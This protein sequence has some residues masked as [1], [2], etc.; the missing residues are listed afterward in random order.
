MTEAEN[1][2]LAFVA[3]LPREGVNLDAESVDW[4][5]R[6]MEAADTCYELMKD[7]LFPGRPASETVGV[8]QDLYNYASAKVM[9]NVARE[10]G[11][12][13]IAERYEHFCQSSYDHLPDFARW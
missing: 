10:R 12:I 3:A 8:V 11:V 13:I 7:T 6:F 5:L 2:V 1:K 4:L 9:A